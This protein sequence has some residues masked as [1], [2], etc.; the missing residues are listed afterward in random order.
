[1][2]SVLSGMTLMQRLLTLVVVCV[3]GL[4]SYAAWSIKTLSEIQVNGPL[5]QRIVLGKDLIADVLPPPAYILESYLTVLQLSRAE[6]AAELPPLI[7]DLRRLKEEYDQRHAFWSVQALDTQTASLLLSQA[8]IHALEFFAIALQEF[9]PAV[10]LRKVDATAASLARMKESYIKHR[11][12]IDRVVRLTKQRNQ[13]AEMGAREE[14]NKAYQKLVAVLVLCLLLLGGFVIVVVRSFIN[15]L[16]AE[17]SVLCEASRKIAEGDLDFAV[18]LRSDDKHSVL[19]KIEEM[20][21]QLKARKWL[22]DER[23]QAAL[24]ANQVNA[25]YQIAVQK[26]RSEAEKKEMYIELSR[27]A[28]FVLNNLL[29]Q[30]QLFKLAAED[31]SDFD[32]NTLALYDKTTQEASQLITRLASLTELNQQNIRGAVTPW[33]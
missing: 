7:A 12:A 8:H 23:Q 27:A 9:V 18:P 3:A 30:M 24:R 32:R 16:G 26:V 10:Q 13:E 15:S 2:H 21:Q 33:A 14:V 4:T 17:P 19:Y 11:K 6:Y 5:Y 25:D 22:E 1:M 20:R 28:Q 31:S 29:N